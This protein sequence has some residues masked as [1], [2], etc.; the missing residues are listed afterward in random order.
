[1]FFTLS[2]LK[3]ALQEQFGARHLAGAAGRTRRFNNKQKK[4]SNV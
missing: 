2:R 4:E 3:S 1:V